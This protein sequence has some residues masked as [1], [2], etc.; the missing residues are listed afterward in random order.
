M[1]LP[2]YKMWD[3]MPLIST[4][5]QPRLAA[6]PFRYRP[7]SQCSWNFTISQVDDPVRSRVPPTSK[8]P[9]HYPSLY[10]IA[11]E[12]F[13]LGEGDYVRVDN[14][15]YAFVKC[16]LTLTLLGYRSRRQCLH[17]ARPRRS[18][19]QQEV[20]TRFPL[21]ATEMQV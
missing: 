15:A 3:E 19:T 4:A 11:F 13:S 10:T 12:S 17:R 9:R 18:C 20:I 7:N 21:S 8:I 16:L 5:Y 1:N 2:S 14:V 6:T